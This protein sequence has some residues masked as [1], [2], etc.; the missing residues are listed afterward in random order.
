[1]KIENLFL[2]FGKFGQR[3]CTII[4][5]ELWPIFFNLQKIQFSSESAQFSYSTRTCIMSVLEKL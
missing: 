2:F 3:L 1:M 4:V 5:Q